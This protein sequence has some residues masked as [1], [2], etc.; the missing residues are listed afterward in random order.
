LS[1]ANNKSSARDIR[2]GM[3]VTRANCDSEHQ[4]YLGRVISEIDY[5]EFIEIMFGDADRSLGQALYEHDRTHYSDLEEWMHYEILWPDA[6]ITIEPRL[7]IH[8]VHV[9]EIES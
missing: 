6:Q 8:P 2:P 5:T 1:T 4:P 7:N 3:F 9:D